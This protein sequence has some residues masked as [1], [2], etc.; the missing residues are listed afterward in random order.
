MKRPLLLFVLLLT[1]CVQAFAQKHTVTGKVLDE[2]GQGY[3]GAGIQVK[4]TVTGAVTDVNGD[5]MLD[6]PDGKNYLVIQALGYDA[7]TVSDTGQQSIVVRLKRAAKELEG[8]VVTALGIKREKRE[9]GYTST[10]LSA[11][12]ITAGQNNSAL[13]GLSGKVAGANVTSSTG[14]PGGSTRVVL[15]GEKS[16]LKDNNALIVIDGVI[17]NNYDRTQSNQLTQV[18]FGNSGNDIDPDE[19]ESMTVLGGPAA[20]AL[21]GAQGANGAIMITTKSGR[22]SSNKRSKIDITYKATYT[23]SDILKAPDVQSQFGQG[24][25]Y[26]G[27]IDDRQ[28]NFSWGLPFDNVVKPWGQIIDGKQQVKPYSYIPNDYR[29][30]FQHGQDL[31]NF[32]S[33]SGGN[34][35]STF[36]LS[37]NSVNSNGIVPNTFYNKY[38]VRFNATT[39]LSNNFYASVNMNYINSY[40]R[41]ENS[42]Q[43]SGGVMQSLLQVPTDIPIYELKNLGSKFNSMDFVDTAGVNRYG[44]FNAYAKN[45]YWAAKYY[46]NRNK[47]DRMV[48][49]M[50][51]GYKKGEFNVF[52]RVGIDVTDDRSYYKTPQFSDQPVD[53]T[54]LYPGND[55][56]SNG[57]YGQVSYTGFNFYNDLVANWAHN[58]NKNFG[59]NALIGDNVTMQNNESLSANID[60]ASNGLVLPGFYNF[61]NNQGPVTVANTLNQRRTYGLYGDIKLNYQRELFLELTGRNDWS[62]TLTAGHNSYFYPGANASWVFTEKLNGTKFKDKVMNYGKV[63]IGTAGVGSDGLAYANN[64]AGFTQSAIGT[65]FGTITP[66]FN[67]VPA[68]SIGKTFGDNGLRPER[69]REF[70]VGTDLSFLKDRLG[71]SFT[72]YNS[73][74][75]DLITAVPVPPSTGFNFQYINVG[76]ISNK[77]EELSIHGAPISTKWGLRWELFGTYTHNVNNVESLTGGVSQ[78]TVGGFSGMSIVAAVGHPY[79]TF[80]AADIAYTADG[81]AIVDQNGV[82]VPTTKP[83]YRGSF[84]PKFQASWGTDLTYKGIKLHVL[85]TTKQGGQF[86]SNTKSLEDF[87]GNAPETALNNR[88]PY[89]WNNSVQQVGTTNNYVTNTTKFVPYNYWVNTV[90]QGFVPAQA[91]VNASYIRLQEIAL[92]YKIP[93]K[94]Y[95]RTPF[96]GLEAGLFGNNLILWT[97]KSN[98]YDDPEETSAGA[99]GNGQGF[100]FNARP[101]LR[102]YGAFVKVTF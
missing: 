61:S 50:N 70:E 37:L 9:L 94:Y 36:Y 49:D 44:Y 45:P 47:T 64:N 89:V 86:Y 54:G 11:D 24:S 78:V 53:V 20:S 18:D 40:S 1:V 69:T 90:G 2:N 102:N 27:I 30:F 17:M 74:T 46:D 80:Y 43:S 63:R 13:S 101:S 42:G 91:L 59:I 31:S 28:D 71:L 15:R 77:G 68:Y 79:G 26:T 96:G 33:L 62:S 60:P 48:G 56:I 3:P 83:V 92:S 75:H 7:V 6:V 8:A 65:A 51:I 29:S 14:G 41:V 23:Q 93:T 19:I 35:A 98:P 58:F 72:Y 57:G 82:P 99:T 87:D 81:H 97:P 21:Y 100:N 84:A 55:Y 12:D 39:Q 85:F 5:F 4:G 52:D 22:K 88:N 95:E 73:L 25:I 16:I 67:A 32:V 76:N 10:T 66:P 38:S 34:E